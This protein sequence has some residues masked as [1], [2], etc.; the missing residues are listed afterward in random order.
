MYE[1]NEVSVKD[2]RAA[3][4][5][6]NFFFPLRRRIQDGCAAMQRYLR[7]NDETRRK[8]SLSNARSSNYSD[9]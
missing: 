9:P 3:R 4:V 7:K 1:V 6:R 2:E 5:N 8:E